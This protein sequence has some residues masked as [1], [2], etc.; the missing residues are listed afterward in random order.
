[1]CIRATP[2]SLLFPNGLKRG[3]DGLIYVP[4]S[5]SDGIR[6]M[7]PQT[8][9]KLTEIATIKLGMPA[10]NLAVDA[11]GDIYAAGLP[12]L[13]DIV[14]SMDDPFGIEAPS[15]IWRISKTSSGYETKKVLEDRDKEILSGVTTARHDAKTG[16]LFV[17]GGFSRISLSWALF[18]APFPAAISFRSLLMSSR[19]ADPI[20]NGLRS[21]VNKSHSE[22]TSSL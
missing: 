1:M 13:L 10:D 6:V 16:R 3:A 22:A 8:N 4:S 18:R 20:H 21:K 12:K 19:C 17:G 2:A 7:E 5:I 11:T 9:G 15:T 14:H